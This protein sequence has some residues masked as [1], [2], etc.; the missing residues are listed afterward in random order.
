MSEWNIGELSNSVN[1]EARLRYPEVAELLGISSVVSAWLPRLALRA[2]TPY[3]YT[4]T[5]DTVLLPTDG[6]AFGRVIQR[7][8]E[9][10]LREI[11][12][13][14]GEQEEEHKW[15]FIPEKSLW[16]DATLGA[17]E[18]VVD[19]DQYAHIF[20]SHLFPA[21]ESVHTHPDAVVRNL[22]IECPWEY[23]ENYLLEA[24][25]PSGNDLILHG[26]MAAR[27]SS[28]SKT[29]DSIVS[30]HGVTTFAL[31]NARNGTFRIEGS[32]RPIETPSTGFHSSPARTIQLAL[33][34]MSGH[35]LLHNSVNPA[36]T[37]EFEPF[38]E[39]A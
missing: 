26:Q 38:D 23:S 13:S 29:A 30:H 36:F 15:L 34:M 14:I 17:Q 5:E 31:K 11:H 18:A 8:R 9:E 24:A 20:L 21:I 33:H 22:A 39:P 3:P 35:V 4:F 27:T 2:E 1:R 19:S 10:G 6:E 12:R 32:S 37:F 7:S 28:S 16:V 25:L